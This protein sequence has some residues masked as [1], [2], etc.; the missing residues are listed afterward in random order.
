[1]YVHKWIIREMDNSALAIALIK[2]SDV[3]FIALLSSLMSATL[4]LRKHFLTFSIEISNRELSLSIV[5]FPSHS[6]IFSFQILLLLFHPNCTYM[7]IR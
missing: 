4:V 7:A 3:N 2:L 5:S 6:L 1:M